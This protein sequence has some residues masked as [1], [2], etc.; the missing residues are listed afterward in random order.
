MTYYKVIARKKLKSGKTIGYTLLSSEGVQF[1]IGINQVNEYNPINVITTKDGIYRSKRGNIIKSII[2]DENITI[3]SRKTSVVGKPRAVYTLV[4]GKPSG[5]Q[6]RILN[7]ID[8]KK[9]IELDKKKYNIKITMQDLSVMTAI[10]GLEYALFERSDKYLI[11]KGNS[12]S[13]E[14]TDSE[15]KYIKSKMYKWVGHTHPG[16]TRR[17]LTPS[18]GDYDLLKALGQKRSMIC[19]S[20][21]MY[22]VFEEENEL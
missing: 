9:A 8:N 4:D 2:V 19:N 3:N 12:S 13:V 16:D 21:G 11:H 10:T 14:F 7:L 18:K 15:I 22:Y 20:I 1:D 6:I 5:T 17:C